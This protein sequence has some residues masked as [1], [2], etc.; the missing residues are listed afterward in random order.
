[1][2]NQPRAHGSLISEVRIEREGP[3]PRICPVC[4][5][6]LTKLAPQQVTKIIKR[7]EDI[8]AQNAISRND[9]I[10]L[11]QEM[12]RVVEAVVDRRIDGEQRQA[13][14]DEIKDRWLE[15]R[16]A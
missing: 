11:M 3:R 7:I 9:F 5:K 10:R 2:E 8:R 12:A 14:K 16:L 13:V 1:L 15:I 4:G 6:T